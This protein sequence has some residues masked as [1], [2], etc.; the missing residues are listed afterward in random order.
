MAHMADGVFEK[1]DGATIFSETQ[2]GLHTRVFLNSAGLT[3]YEAKDLGNFKL[4]TDAYPEWTQSYVVTGAEQIE[5]FKVIIAAIKK[6]FPD[7]QNK[8]IAHIPTGFL[9]LTTGK[10]SSRLGN[11]LT[12]ESLIADL[13]ESAKVRA[14]ESRA[15]DANQL[16]TDIAVAALKYDVLKQT[17][18][19]NIVFDKEHALSLEGDSGPYLQYTYARS[20]AI[21]AKAREQGIEPRIAPDTVFG[22]SETLV[23]LITRF[24][25]VVAYATEDLQPHAIAHYLIS[26]ASAFNAWYAQEQILDG[27]DTVAQKV[28][29]VEAFGNT[30]KK[31]LYLLGIP[32]PEKM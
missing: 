21:V 7:T 3:T 19:R 30:I 31:G 23:R 14:A 16:A 28:A 32:A 4:K 26:I 27:S 11:V 15:D 29:I 2:S 18:G 20:R 10:M 25:T 9:T 24:P 22:A 5:Y 1:S 8:K 12:G 13:E 17:N 6:V